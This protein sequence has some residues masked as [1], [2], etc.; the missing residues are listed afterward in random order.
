MT[1]G[2]G[3]TYGEEGD[4][5]RGRLHG[6]HLARDR[7]HGRSRCSRGSCTRTAAWSPTRS[8][9]PRLRTSRTSPQPGIT[10]GRRRSEDRM[11]GKQIEF[12]PKQTHV[13]SFEV[14]MLAICDHLRGRRADHRPGHRPR[15]RV[16]PDRLSGAE[17]T[18][19]VSCLKRR[20]R[21][22]ARSADAGPQGADLAALRGDRRR[23]RARL[24][25]L[26]RLSA[27]RDRGHPGGGAWRS[28]PSWSISCPRTPRSGSCARGSTATRSGS[29]RSR[30]RA[31]TARRYAELAVVR[32]DAETGEV[33]EFQ[34][35][36]GRDAR[37]RP[38]SVS[39]CAC[40]SSS[41]SPASTRAC[42]RR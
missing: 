13:R 6:P 41:T 23:A 9:Q 27:G 40:S 14:A 10:A 31:R 33:V 22:V 7:V 36:E 12:P 35:A 17:Y 8:A 3:S 28:P 20:G 11:N 21:R 29:S 34:R 19:G 5:R 42:S 39:R 30:P 32:I 4:R 25:R 16:P 2:P 26:A 15:R 18:R 1:F 37:A 38:G 24:R